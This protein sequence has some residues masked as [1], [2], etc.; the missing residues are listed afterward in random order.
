MYT[1]PKADLLVDILSQ[2]SDLTEAA[3]LK[4][5]H[6]EDGHQKLRRMHSLDIAA[7]RTISRQVLFAEQV[8]KVEQVCHQS[9]RQTSVRYQSCTVVNCRNFLYIRNGIK[10]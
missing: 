2:M 7:K 1:L 5:K 6:Q 3:D 4:D 9:E 8:M 10:H